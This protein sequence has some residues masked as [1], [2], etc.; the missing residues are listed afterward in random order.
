[1]TV[2]I[3]NYRGTVY[4]VFDSLKKARAF[5]DRAF[6]ENGDA[7]ILERTVE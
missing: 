2:W 3:V 5:A 4:A 1:M 7:D 6:G